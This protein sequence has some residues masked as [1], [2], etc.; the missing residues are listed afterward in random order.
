M[1]YKSEIDSSSSSSLSAF[2]QI[3]LMNFSK[4]IHSVNHKEDI[5]THLWGDF[6]LMESTFGFSY[7]TLTLIQFDGDDD[8]F[9]L[10]IVGLQKV[11]LKFTYRSVM[12]SE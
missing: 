1:E 9:L 6:L 11:N 3:W 5:P 8:I 7:S 10:A 2:S 4:D 12:S